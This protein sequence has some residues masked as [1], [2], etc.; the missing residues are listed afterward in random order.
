MTV[1]L[2]MPVQVVSFVLSPARPQSE[3]REVPVE[4]RPPRI[5][6]RL[7]PHLLKRVLLL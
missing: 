3:G 6:G 4:E 5:H 7:R 2:E 1:S